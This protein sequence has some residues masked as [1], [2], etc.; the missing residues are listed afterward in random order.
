MPSPGYTFKSIFVGYCQTIM[1]GEHDGAT[2][3]GEDV[4]PPRVGAAERRDLCGVRADGGGVRRAGGAV[5]APDPHAGSAR[6]GRVGRRV[7][8]V[9]EWGAVRGLPGSDRGK[10]AGIV[11]TVE[12]AWRL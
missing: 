10:P 8:P 3:E 11:P 7:E 12:S 5:D 4:G 2:E 1:K 9:D 6:T